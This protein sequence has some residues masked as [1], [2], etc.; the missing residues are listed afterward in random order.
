MKPLK[1][2]KPRKS[3]VT[4][5]VLLL[6]IAVLFIP[7]LIP[8]SF[9]ASWG[10]NLLLD[11]K[12]A[13]PD[14]RPY[15]N[16]LDMEADWHQA[17]S[18]LRD[19]TPEVI[20]D[21][22]RTMKLKYPDAAMY[23]V[24]SQG[25]TQLQLPEQTTVPDQWTLEDTIAFMKA[26][27]NGDPFTVVAYIGGNEEVHQGFMVFELPRKFM[28]ITDDERDDGRFYGVFLV[29]MLGSF[30]L[31]SAWFF[32][33]IRKRLLRLEAAMSQ[34]GANGLPSPIQEGRPD[35]IGRLEQAFNQMLYKLEH[36]RQREQEEENLRKGLISHLSHDL[37]TPLTVLGSHLYSLRQEPLTDRGKQSLALMETKIS[38]L[39]GLMDHLLSY[40]LLTSKRYALSMERLDVMRLVR[41][42]AAAWYPVWEKAGIRADIELPEQPLYWSVDAQGFRRVLDNLFQN[43]V[44]HAGS[45]EYV[46]IS[47][48]QE[49]GAE[50]L[51]ISDRGPGMEVVS[52]SHGSGLGLQI[53]DLL[54]REMNLARKTHTSPAGT[55]ISIYPLRAPK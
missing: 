55:A 40:S 27:V 23:W 37:R 41:E 35:E 44:R 3:L 4:R 39:S 28:V 10:V 22:L 2:R 46:G 43:L 53:V 1:L 15:G 16:G 11:P 49:N 25:T 18:K 24:D 5:Y 6:A 26:R 14:V 7:V 31:L 12:G 8:V 47:M 54:L 45:G 51:V 13:G 29:I 52:T 32:S 38:D 19:A 20:G 21:T 9:I 33:D 42:S 36:S 30:I 48:K 34:T 17:S 50:A